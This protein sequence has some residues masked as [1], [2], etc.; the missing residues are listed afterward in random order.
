MSNNQI[1]LSNIEYEEIKQSLIDFLKNQTV[2]NSYNFNGSIIQT[3]ISL[4]SYNTLYYALYS[5]ILA[6]EMFLDTARREQSLISLL[7]PLGIVLP[8]KTSS[9]AKINVSGVSDALI[10]KFTRFTGTNDNGIVYNFYTLRSFSPTS[11]SSSYYENIEI[12]EGRE[13]IQNKDITNSFDLE[14]QSYFIGNIDIDLST[15]V[16]EV[17]SGV[18]NDPSGWILW[19]RIDNIG[20]SSENL[21]QNIYF[22]ERFDTGF[23]L[24]FG[25]INSLGN[26]IK[27]TDQIRISYLVSSGSGANNIVSFANSAVNGLN[28][29]IGVQLSQTSFGGL[30]GPDVDY[31]KFVAPKFFAAQNRAVTKNDFLAISTEYLRTKGYTITKDNFNIFGGEELFPPK[32][33]RVFIATDV[34]PQNDILDLVAYL[35]TKCALTILPEYVSSTNEILTYDVKIRFS[36]TNL[37]DTQ[38]LQY[39]NTIRQYLI[40]NFSAISKYNISIGSIVAGINNTFSSIITTNQTKVTINYNKNF[41]NILNDGFTVNLENKIFTGTNSLYIT[42][43]FTDSSNRTILLSANVQ[44]NEINNFKNLQTHIL[45]SSGNYVIN[46]NFV[47]GRIQASTGFV[48]IYK[49][50]TNN[51]SLKLQIDG[52]TFNSTTNTKFTITPNIISEI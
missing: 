47:Y 4:L 37:S 31:F 15:L 35:K 33:G 25:K 30:D 51:L 6:N 20:D 10:P 2:L 23:E 44:P 34:I 40:N 16:V 24:Q 22:I 39:I 11:S 8:S 48:E 18:S 26:T 45:N 32:Y 3:V 43:P 21:S 49:N 9:R 28:G 36:S 7:K 13:L 50:V 29:N 42:E 17:N 14:D 27:S 38:K 12:V 19:N 52:D 46:N 1:N 5:N 41:N